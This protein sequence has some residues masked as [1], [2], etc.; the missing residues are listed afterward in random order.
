MARDLADGFWTNL[1][2]I[3]PL[4]GTA[5][6]DERFDDRLPDPSDGGRQEAASLFSGA[7][8]D[9]GR[10]NRG[11]L[12]ETD[13]TTL[14]LLEAISRRFLAGISHRTDR[15]APASHLWGPSNLLAEV[16]SFQRADTPERVDRYEGRLR[17]FPAFLASMADVAR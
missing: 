2:R 12:D 11:S 1:I 13:R 3:E 5:A 9:L 8:E 10:I 16:A 17:A 14:D 4:L 15:L 6:G 7:L